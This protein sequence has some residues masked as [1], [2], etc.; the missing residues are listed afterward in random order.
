M[1][2][3]FVN[4]DFVIAVAFTVF[5]V[6]VYIVARGFPVPSWATVGAGF[7]P[8]IL[9]VLLIILS[10]SLVLQTVLAKKAV[11]KARKT[12]ADADTL[13]EKLNV[14]LEEAER[15]QRSEQKP[16]FFTPVLFGV[17]VLYYLSLPYLGYFLTKILGTTVLI[18]LIGT[19]DKAALRGLVYKGF[20]IG[21]GLSVF[22][23]I[24]FQRFMYIRLPRGVV[25]RWLIG[26]FS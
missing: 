18:V 2:R 8:R 1:R 26:F 23:Y 7:V 10:A 15:L 16:W 21:V 9:A 3:S 25:V 5:A 13:S 19:S 22:V 6:W 11:E 24:L 17:F 12:D 20:A 4:A 14:S